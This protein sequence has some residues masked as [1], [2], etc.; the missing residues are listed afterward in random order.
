M[1]LLGIVYSFGV[2]TYENIEVN[3]QIQ[4]F[5]KRANQTP[6]IT[7]M[8]GEQVVYYYEVPRETSYELAD[9]RSVFS[10]TS[11]TRPGIK[12]DILVARESPFPQIP[13]IHQ[14]ITYYFG[15]HS[16]L[17]IDDNAIVE[18]TGMSVSISEMFDMI[19]HNGY[20]GT[21]SFAAP[22]VISPNY[23][24]EADFWSKSDPRNEYYQGSFRNEFIVLR[25]KTSEAEQQIAVDYAVD[26]VEKGAFYNFLFF[27]DTKYKY[28]CTDIVSR[29]YEDVYA[30]TGKKVRIND[31]GFITSANDLILSK[32]TY[33]TIYKETIKG[34]QHIYYLADVEE[35]I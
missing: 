27:L 2:A 35:I 7:T 25:T 9:T 31:D 11:K 26:K 23:W 19:T 10:N 4:S 34:E 24:M 32:D 33:M 13:V 18:A 1:A 30:Q 21:Q 12:G 28:Y 17:V 20:G 16:A 8:I 15:G 3:N 6:T 14:F 5:K 22:V 29:A